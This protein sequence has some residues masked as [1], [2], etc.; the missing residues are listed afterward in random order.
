HIEG[1]AFLRD[2]E[3]DYY[4]YDDARFEVVGRNSGRRIAFG[5]EV[6]IRVKGV[7]MRRRTIDFELIVSKRK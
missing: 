3:D 5:E 2:I 6:W 7:D 4:Y 1:M